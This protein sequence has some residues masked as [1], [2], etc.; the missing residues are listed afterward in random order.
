MR[1]LDLGIGLQ[2]PRVVVQTETLNLAGGTTPTATIDVGRSGLIVNYPDGG[3][4]PLPTIEAH[5]E[6]AR[7]A[8]ATPWS[9]AGITSSTAAL[10]PGTFTV[11]AEEATDVF[12]PSG[13]T[14]RGVP[15]APGDEAVLIR[16]DKKS[17]ADGPNTEQTNNAT[18]PR[19]TPP[20]LPSR[21]WGSVVDAVFASNSDDQQTYGWA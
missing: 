7:S 18:S 13:G 21:P 10:R 17:S 3:L 1:A 12:G 2:R 6:H 16:G 9:A 4:S 8:G 20:P 15:L 5:I 14:F 11:Y 19:N